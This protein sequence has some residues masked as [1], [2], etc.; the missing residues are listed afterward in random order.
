[1]QAARQAH[2]ARQPAAA[3]TPATK[4]TRSM[5]T[6][7]RA[8]TT[9]QRPRQG[10]AAG[11]ELGFAGH[12]STPRAACELAPWSALVTERAAKMRRGEGV[13][14]SAVLPWIG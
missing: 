10:E 14:M 7:V 1:M 9:G 12:D 13:N 3:R 2:T 4:R 11:V 6:H 8:P 5:T